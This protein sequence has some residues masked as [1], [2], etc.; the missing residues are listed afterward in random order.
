MKRKQRILY[1]KGE[2]MNIK[3][4]KLIDLKAYKNNAKV[5]NEKQIEMIA[6]SIRQF[7]FRQPLV[8]DRNN[9]IVVGH[10][11]YF[12]AKKIGLLKVPCE[13]A[14]DLTDDQ[15]KAYR[16]VDNKLN[17]SPWDF[18]LLGQ[19][20]ADV[21]IAGLG[22]DLDFDIDSNF[23]T[24]EVKKGIEQGEEDKIP[25]E[26]TRRVET[27][28]I[29]RLGNHRL[30][31]G[32]STDANTIDKLFAG[33]KAD[34]TITSPP[35][36]MGRT[37][38]LRK[39]IE[40]GV[41]SRDGKT[42]YGNGGDSASEWAN[43]MET[44]FFVSQ[45]FSETQFINVMMVADNKINL[46]KF[47]S[48]HLDNLVDI[49]VWNKHTCP[50]QIHENVLNNGYEFVFCFDNSQN[51]RRIKF[52]DFKGSKSNYIETQ[53][54]INSYADV[55]KA[56]FSVEFVTSI[57]DINGKAKSVYEPF[58]GTGTTLIACEQ[59]GITCYTCE[60]KPEYCDIIIQR[61]ETFTGE[62]AVRENG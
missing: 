10:G 20:L 43:L 51:T 42:F 13:Y 29:W 19:E 22:F 50:P 44:F 26:A 45:K 33:N 40:Q 1:D 46:I 3:E 36:G 57:L 11:R 61:W 9:E 21:D 5:H 60:L 7:G 39:H 6:E 38:H 41:V 32:D 12:A 18:D 15:I 37:A 47:V 62:K 48:N 54:E 59:K 27:G 55:H 56:V 24:D 31:C 23:G 53:K 34:I 14:D 17:E 35:Y 52:G 16:L 58:G 28:D 25:E 49:I 2:F 30:I 4:I 8:I